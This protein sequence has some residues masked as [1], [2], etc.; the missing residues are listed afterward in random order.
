MNNNVI[1]KEFVSHS[2]F[3]ESILFKKDTTYPKISIVVPSFNQAVF[4]ERTILSILNQN[5]P[6]LEF[7]LMDGGS[8]DGSLDIIKKYEKYLSYW[9]SEKDRGQ[10]HAINKGFQMATGELVAWQNSDDIYLP[11]AFHKI[12]DI[13]MR[14]NY[15]VYF[16]NV[17]LTDENDDILKEMKYIPFSVLHLLFEWNITSQAV[18]WKRNLFNDIGLLD[19][20]LNVFFDWDW[21]IRIGK[22]NK[23][24]K[25]TNDFLGA[26][27]IHAAA[28]LATIK[29]RD[30]ARSYV[31]KKNNIQFN[32]L[33]RII[34]K[35]FIFMRR[36]MYYVLQGDFD[37]LYSGIVRR[38]HKI[39]KI[40]SEFR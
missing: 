25:F 12:A 18:F 39:C 27:R 7:I 30:S 21:F 9:V 19:D 31:F 5:Y 37:Y 3:D 10:A 13:A 6:N 32:K 24:F 1:L 8:T 28:K 14:S 17:Y 2:C 33:E 38:C 40:T 11:G 23:R 29:N 20:S 22:R 16:G 26:Y 4:L 15:D 34:K 36:I 35:G